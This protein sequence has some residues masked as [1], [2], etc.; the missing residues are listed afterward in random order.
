MA[1]IKYKNTVQK[2]SVRYIVFKEDHTWYAV[3]LEFNIVE[4][5]DSPEVALANLF[6]AIS[7]YLES[8][9][10]IKGARPHVLNQKT[11][12]EYES[13]WDKLSAAKPVP[14]PYQV[15]TFGRRLVHA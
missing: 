15:A 5:G 11:D 8:F 2:G 12:Q 3:G 1:K 7:G 13:L 14:S 9:K 10:K 6:N 4:E